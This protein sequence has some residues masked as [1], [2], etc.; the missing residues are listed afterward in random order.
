MK[1]RFSDIALEIRVDR[2]PFCSVQSCAFAHLVGERHTKWK[3]S[4]SLHVH[5]T[6]GGGR[7]LHQALGVG[8]SAADAD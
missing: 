1:Q 2:C 5:C 3:A 8:T 7:E 6:R 4:F